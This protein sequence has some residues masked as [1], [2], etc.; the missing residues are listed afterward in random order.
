[1]AR[2][3][4]RELCPPGW[5]QRMTALEPFYQQ[6]QAHYDISNQFYE[7]FLDP[8]MTYSCAYFERPDNTLE[9]AQ[10]AKM[11]LALGKCDLQP[12]QRLLD[13]G[14]GWGGTLRRAVKKFGARTVG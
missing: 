14:C 6:V 5:S 2:A 11:D 10:R 1:M 3:G 13:I 4:I 8:S 9:E 12:G 7:L